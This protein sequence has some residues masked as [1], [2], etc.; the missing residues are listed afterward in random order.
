VDEDFGITPVEAMA[1]GKI[2]LATNEGGYRETVV[3]GRTG[4]LLPPSPEAFAGTIRQLDEA[5]LRSMREA[6][7]TRAKEF[8]EE[9]FVS[10][11]KAAIERA[12]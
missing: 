11:M 3:H 9:V 1:A 2:V 4:Y 12:S 7:V 5:A 8:D 6:C 10:K